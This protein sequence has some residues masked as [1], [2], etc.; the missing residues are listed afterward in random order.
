MAKE[1]RELSGVIDSDINIEELEHVVILDQTFQVL[2]T[3]LHGIIGKYV[4]RG[5]QKKLQRVQNSITFTQAILY[6][7]N[8]LQFADRQRGMN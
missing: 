3:C 2:Y 6:F 7:F 8:Q 1:I 4:Q 5:K